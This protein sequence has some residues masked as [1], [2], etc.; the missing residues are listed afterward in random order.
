MRRLE[1]ERLRDLPSLF[2]PPRIWDETELP[3]LP[4][5]TA[6]ER[7]SWDYETHHAGRA[8]PMTLMRRELTDL[9]IRPIETCY[10]V[11]GA[12][13]PM[14]REPRL[15]IAG[16]VM[17]RQR[18]PTAKGVQFVTLED[19]TGF[20]QCIVYPVLQERLDHIFVRNAMIVRGR[21]QIEGNW[22]GFIVEDAWVLDAMF[23]GY[24]GYASYSGGRDRWVRKQSQ[25]TPAD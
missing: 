22:R 13:A 9:E 3:N 17:L 5:L 20:I 12:A 25:T 1:Q 21:L 14:K 6:V 8:H 10:R 7:I 24:E 11:G 4:R 2:E 23:G 19:E 16:I 15:T 18:P